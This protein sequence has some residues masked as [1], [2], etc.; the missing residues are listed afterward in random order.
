MP[1]Q[2]YYDAWMYLVRQGYGDLVH[3]VI[4]AGSPRRAIEHAWAEYDDKVWDPQLCEEFDKDY[5]Y[6]LV[7]ARSKKR[8]GVD[9][10][11]GKSFSSKVYGGPWEGE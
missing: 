9:E 7:G 3:G 6:G 10:A 2:C 1:A 8:Y 4:V 5:Y 11:V